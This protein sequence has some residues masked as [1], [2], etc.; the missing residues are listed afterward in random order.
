M[1][2]AHLARRIIRKITPPVKPSVKRPVQDLRCEPLEDRT[3]PDGIREGR[4]RNERR[5][6]ATQPGVIQRVPK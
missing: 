3:V 6:S 2:I 5:G 4:N 1:R